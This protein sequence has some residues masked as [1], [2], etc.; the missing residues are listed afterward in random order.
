M[1]FPNAHVQKYTS[2]LYKLPP[3]L[4]IKIIH[5]HSVLLRKKNPDNIVIYNFEFQNNLILV[6]CLS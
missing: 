4:I 5:E 6:L 1:N 3:Y 2:S